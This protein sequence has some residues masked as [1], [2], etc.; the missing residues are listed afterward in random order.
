MPKKKRSGT[1]MILMIGVVVLLILGVGGY[2][3]VRSVQPETTQEKVVVT[4]VVKPEPKPQ[5]E[6]EPQREEPALTESDVFPVEVTPGTD[7]D[8]DGLS[9]TEENTVYKTDPRMPDTDSDGFLDGN[10]VFH[11]YNPAATG[12]LL[13]QGIVVVQM[14]TAGSVNYSFMFPAIWETSADGDVFVLDAQT[15]QGFRISTTSKDSEQTFETWVSNMTALEDPLE[16]TTKNGLPMLSSQNQ[17]M[18]Y[19]DLGSAVLVMEYDTGTKARV[20]YLQ[21]MQMM[22]NSVE[23]V[24]QEE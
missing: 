7:S 13:E 5:P 10:E 9:D 19:V 16:G 2:F 4:P 3:L 22:L 15:G 18:T 6:P 11:R 14:G 1:K 8:S 21:T 12:T 17:L 20:D 24:S 23:V